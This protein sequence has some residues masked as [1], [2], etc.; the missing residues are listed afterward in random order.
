MISVFKR[1]FCFSE[2]LFKAALKEVREKLRTVRRCL[3]DA[4]EA[5]R[6]LDD[7]NIEMRTQLATEV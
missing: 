6:L 4:E 2:V 1:L 3:D 5:R 7:S